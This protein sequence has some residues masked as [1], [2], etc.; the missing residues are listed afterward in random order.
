[1][2]CETFPSRPH[3]AR[4]GPG[5]L[6]SDCAFA[7]ATYLGGQRLTAAPCIIAVQDLHGRIALSPGAESHHCTVGPQH[8][9]GLGYN[10]TAALL[11]GRRRLGSQ[12]W[13]QPPNCATQCKQLGSV[14]HLQP[15]VSSNASAYPAGTSNTVESEDNASVPVQSEISSVCWI[16]QDPGYFPGPRC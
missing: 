11:Q 14:R 13:P 3:T 10:T 12:S 2:I 4:M 9:P 1:M 7:A 8:K 6:G 16:A 15:E 5:S